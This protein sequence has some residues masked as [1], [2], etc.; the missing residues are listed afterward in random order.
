MIINLNTK[1]SKKN[2]RLNVIAGPDLKSEKKKNGIPNPESQLSFPRVII[3][4]NIK[5][6]QSDSR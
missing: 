5:R 1:R 3:H 2:L 6:I 4:K